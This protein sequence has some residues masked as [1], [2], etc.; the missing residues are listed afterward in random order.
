[1]KKLL[2]IGATSFVPM[3][4]A[5]ANVTLEY[6]VEQGS[7]VL[8]NTKTG[9]QETLAGMGTWFVPAGTYEVN[10]DNKSCLIPVKSLAEG[11][12]YKVFNLRKECGIQDCGTTACPP[13]I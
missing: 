9:G 1:M 13:L 7:A 11:N 8:V 6:Q 12:R 5:L 3:A 10:I 4:Q 2:L